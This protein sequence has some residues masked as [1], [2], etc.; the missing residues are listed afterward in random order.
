MSYLETLMT[1]VTP[2]EVEK[3]NKKYERI[4]NL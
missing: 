2:E 1:N 4:N 3:F